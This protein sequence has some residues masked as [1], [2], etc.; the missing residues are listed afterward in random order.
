VAHSP[1]L[2]DTISAVFDS[3]IVASLP[4]DRLLEHVVAEKYKTQ[5]E[6]QRPDYS[7]RMP[8]YDISD[9]GQP[10]DHSENK[11]KEKDAAIAAAISDLELHSNAAAA[12]T[13]TIMHFMNHCDACVRCGKQ[14]CRF[15]K[16]SG[17]VERTGMSMVRL[18]ED[19]ADHPDPRTRHFDV[20]P[21]VERP[22]HD[23]ARDPIEPLDARPLAYEMKRPAIQPAFPDD[24]AG[25]GHNF[26]ILD[27]LDDP[28][29]AGVDQAIKDKLRSL[30]RTQRDVIRDL[31]FSANGLVSEF[32]H[33]LMSVAKCNMAIY[34]M[35]TAASAGH[36]RERQGSVHVYV[37]I[38]L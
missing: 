21:P 38:C 29:F 5:P 30:N 24:R 28:Q 36:S 2:I 8:T 22:K 32:N 20:E 18:Q 37:Q 9:L 4:P 23:Y 17:L 19:F 13:R 25:S 16:P 15:A 6:V 33:V 10:C 11:Q 27:S 35:G 34:P 7:S 3:M 26:D 1:V 12:S 14:C 31:L